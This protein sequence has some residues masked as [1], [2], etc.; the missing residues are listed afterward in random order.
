MNYKNAPEEYFCNTFCK[1]NAEH[2]ELLNASIKL[3]K[4]L[5]NQT[6]KGVPVN[7]SGEVGSAMGF[8]NAS[9]MNATGK[10]LEEL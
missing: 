7:Y 5:K 4:A 8:M 2:K 1:I 10:T 3:M 9:I 6:R